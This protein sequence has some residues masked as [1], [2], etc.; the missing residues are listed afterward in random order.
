MKAISFSSPESACAKSSVAST[1]LGLTSVTMIKMML[2]VDTF[3]SKDDVEDDKEGDRY[4]EDVD[5]D[6]DDDDE[7]AL[8]SH[9]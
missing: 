2:T 7:Q 1:L 4:D 9:V 8:P 6:D 5:S 3:I